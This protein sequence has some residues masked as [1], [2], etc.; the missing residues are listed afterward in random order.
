MKYLKKFALSLSKTQLRRLFWVGLVLIGFSV[1]NIEILEK[2]EIWGI[3]GLISTIN[4]FFPWFSK[5]F[6]ST[7]VRVITGIYFL[8]LIVIL[9]YYVTSRP[10]AI[11]IRHS[12]L[13]NNLSSYDKSEV[14]GYSVSE[15]DINL[16][17]LMK[18]DAIIKAIKIQDD[19]IE[20][21]LRE[22]NPSTEIFYYGIA[23]IPLIFR[24]GFQIG[25]G[26]NVTP[27]HQFRNDRSLFKKLSN[28]K[29][30]YALNLVEKLNEHLSS[31][32]EMLVVVAI[33]FP[34]SNND[35]IVFQEKNFCCDL[36]F[37]M[38][39]GMFG[40]DVINSYDEMER[41][42]SEILSSIRDIVSKKE[43]DRIHL[44][45]AASSDF[46]FNLARKFS[47]HHDPE[48]IVYQYE[49]NSK[50]KYPWAISNKLSADRAVI[51]QTISET[52]NAPASSSTTTA[53]NFTAQPAPPSTA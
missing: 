45:L 18:S 13:S 31:F 1:F 24:A 48:I 19:L 10:K 32:R 29:E 20:G 40:V 43:I 47:E 9:Y 25:D 16:V 49:R 5:V 17:N 6:S 33:S 30:T 36:H 3:S 37:E 12:S 52:K 15:I 34:V 38:S 42:Q 50:E 46:I 27:L 35:L 51:Y 8:F 11:V 53:T 26:G 14:S 41:L 39:K 23:H 44:V 4:N 2:I 21:V 28:R 7:I 22:C